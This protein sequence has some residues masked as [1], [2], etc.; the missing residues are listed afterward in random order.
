[1]NG[2][3]YC[4]G[5]LIGVGGVVL[6]FFIGCI[7]MSEFNDDY[8]EFKKMKDSKSEASTQ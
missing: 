8:Q 4:A 1:M 3:G 7:F 2:L 6:G 5:T